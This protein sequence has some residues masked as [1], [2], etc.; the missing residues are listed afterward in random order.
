M[1][2][3]WETLEYPKILK[4]L[5]G[6]T[7]FSA[8]AALVLNL[9]PAESYR[10]AEALLALTAEARSVLVERPD[11]AL[12]GVTDIRPWVEQARRGALIEPGDL[13]RLRDT[14]L[15]AGRIHR[16]FT[17]LENQ[18]PGLA[19]IA[20]RILPQPALADAISG[21]LDD[22]G[23]VR[24]SASPELTRIRRELRVT[25][26]RVQEKL[27]RM[28]TSPDV[29][30]YL[31]EA[32]ITRRGGRFVI[33]VQANFKNQV[34]GIVHDRSSSG[35]TL[36]IEPLPVIDL[37][38]ALRELVLAEEEEIQRILAVLT[39]QIAAVADEL[40]AALEAL[41][42]IDLTFAKA[43][44]A[45][46]LHASRPAI[47]PPIKTLPPSEGGNYAP[48]TML[49]LMGARHP[50]LDP[51][52]VVPIDV[53][54]DNDTH[55]LII[56][57][58]NTGGKTVTLKTVGLLTLMAQAGMH[59]PVDDG[60]ALTYFDAV[61][62]DIG[63]EQSIEQSLSTFSSHLANIMSFFADANQRTL[64]LLDELGAGTDPA[65]GSAL[66][67]SLLE[68]LRRKRCTALIATHYPELKLYAHN[69]PGITNASMQF[70]T[71]T[72]A[73]TFRLII[74]LPGRSNAFAIAHRLGL[75]ESVVR[76]AQAMISGEAL[77]AEDML[78]DLHTLRIETARARD[79]AR[80][81]RREAEV[82]G[83]NLRKRL[84]AIDAER[85][86]V[87]RQARAD[88]QADL[89]AVQEEVEALRRRLR[90]MPVAEVAPVVE[91]AEHVLDELAARSLL[92]EPA[93]LAQEIA[94][95]ESQAPGPPQLGDVVRVSSLGVEGTLVDIEGERAQVQAGAVRT[96]VPLDSL[97]VV[98]RAASLASLPVTTAP[99]RPAVSPG[100]QLDIRGMTV[101]DAVQRLDR[102]LDDA[103]MARL[104]WV[105]IVHGKGTGML[106]RGVRRFLSDHPLALSYESA[107]ER[108]GG[109]GVTIVQLTGG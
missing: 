57:G 61:Y 7:D 23:E 17:R 2:R 27:Q 59:I 46:D 40:H 85:A 72:L 54:L 29:A 80:Q 89:A 67:R 34:R 5:A 35:M 44:Y 81:S 77:R 106:R 18:W 56:T 90:V 73:P 38:N 84:A 103:V 9:T 49:Q 88:A 50:L 100:I 70:D 101:E 1:N 82:L 75:P 76:E 99:S 65:E 14:V 98:Q 62:A 97:E 105:R 64:V 32:L 104:P 48:G 6:Y 11:F 30:R 37:N 3:H 74:G 21:V 92:S 26:S 63:D 58:P 47:H 24:D 33:P 66:A 95:P 45:D 8:G 42:E 93:S 31:Q 19:D 87:L 108:E 79:A 83:A 53:V 71:E 78:S 13:L 51:K 15:A 28:L 55:M 16:L 43:R 102:Y 10:E 68:A 12:G 86:E 52:T 25:Q 60:A 41:A 91:E 69:T 96:R 94:V 20:W 22:R 36:F 4:R 39:S 107:P 109:D